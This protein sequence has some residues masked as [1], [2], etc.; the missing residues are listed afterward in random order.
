[1]VT[2]IDRRFTKAMRLRSRG[3]FRRVYERKCWA[4]DS[5]IRMAGQ[6][7]DLPHPRIGLS[8]GR[9]V[10]NAVVRNRWKRLLR[11][12]YRLS[13]SR[14]PTGLDFIVV[15]RENVKPELQPLMESLVNLSWRVSKRLKREQSQSRRQRRAE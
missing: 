10:G 14:L 3:D 7:S 13:R 6:L 4:G 2:M 5:L 1:M 15:P 8:V 11:E 12:A 9:V